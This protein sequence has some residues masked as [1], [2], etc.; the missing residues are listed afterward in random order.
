MQ[1]IR[2]EKYGK[3]KH[4]IQQHYQVSPRSR[5][6]SLEGVVLTL[7]GSSSNLSLAL[8]AA[9]RAVF[10]FLKSAYDDNARLLLNRRAGL[11]ELH[12]R[13]S[14]I[15]RPDGIYD[16]SDLRAACD[17]A[18]NYLRYAGAPSFRD[19]QCVGVRFSY[20]PSVGEVNAG[21][22][23]ANAA[24]VP[25]PVEPGSAFPDESSTIF[26][27]VNLHFAEWPEKGRVILQ[28]M[29]AVVAPLFK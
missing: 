3:P 18:L 1:M 29:P 22:A 21:F 17:Q 8:D 11:Y 14:I 10:P 27:T 20:Y 7:S 15:P 13:I 28:S 25:L 19:R 26:K 12:P 5:D 23:G 2:F 16:I 24:P 9:G 6:A 4:L